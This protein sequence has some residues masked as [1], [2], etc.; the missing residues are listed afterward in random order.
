[1]AG[2][3]GPPT[4]QILYGG[5]GINNEEHSGGRFTLGFWCDE[6]QSF[7][8]E[9]SF[10]FL[11]ERS[12][13][14]TAMSSGVPILARPFFN[15]GTGL[16][17]AQLIA[18]PG[19]LAGNALVSSSTRLWGAEANFR[20]NCWRGCYW[21]MDWITGFRYLALDES[22]GVLE[23]LTVPDT[24]GPLAGSQIVVS[25][26]FGTHNN[27][28]GGQFGPEFQFRSGPWSLDLLTK[29][30]LGSV[31]QTANVNGGTLFAVPGMPVS[32]QS[33]GL[34]ALPSNSGH[35]SRDRFAVVPEV[36]VKVGYQLTAHVRCFVGYSFLY[37]SDVARPGH[38][39]DPVLN[40]SQLPS[41]IGPGA[42]SGAPRPGFSFKGADFW[43]QGVSFGLEIRY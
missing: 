19:V 5:T 32:F 9:G 43:V 34:L 2:V 23:R 8:L 29:V 14:F 15:V 39:V 38:Q 10:L 21:R 3:L 36:G 13:L 37:I 31:H 22:L 18:F 16:N 12:N 35:F 26:Q 42:L 33:G 17:D 41:Q 20:W 7:G 30:G 28:Y 4:T 24:G 25:D 40:V 11:G 1:M 27:F 6:E